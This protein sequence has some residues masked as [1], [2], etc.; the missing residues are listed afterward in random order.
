MGTYE[1]LASFII[2]H[3]GGKENIKS[4]THCLTRLRFDLINN[5]KIEDKT[6]KASKEIVSTQFA[7]GKYQVVIGAHVGDVYEDVQVKLGGVP[8]GEDASGEKMSPLDQFTSVITQ[9]MTPV[10][11]VLG[12]CGLIAAVMAILVALNLVTTTDGAYLILNAMGNACLTFFPVILGYTSAKAFKMNPFSGMILGCALMAPGLAESMSTGD[13]LF[14]VFDSTPLAIPV[15]KTF[16]GIPIMFPSSGYTSTVIPIVFATLVA[17]KIEHFANPRI[18]SVMRMFFTPMV[19]VLGA[20]IITMLVIGPISIMLTNLISWGISALLAVAPVVAYAVY[21]LVYQPLVI[22]GLHWALISVGLIEFATSGSSLL[23]SLIFPASFAH[24]AVCAAVML[25]TKNKILRETSLAAVISACFCIIEPSIYGVTLPVKKRFGICMI[26]GTI[27]GVIN[28]VLGTRMYA[29]TMGI[30]GFAGFI[31]PFTGETQGML[32]CLL[33]VAVTM[34]IGF[35]LTWVTYTPIEDGA[36]K[37]EPLSESKPKLRHE[38]ASVS[39]PVAGVV[40][41]LSE[42]ND[43]AFSGGALGGG[44]CVTLSEGTVVAPFDG[45]LTTLFPTGHALG[46]M[47]DNGVELLVHVGTE[48]VGLPKGTFVKHTVQGKRVHAGD[49]L[50]TFDPAM[51]TAQGCSLETAVVVSNADDYLD[52]LAVGEGAVSVGDELLVAVARELTASANE[53]VAVSAVARV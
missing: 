46:I 29:V 36:P 1:P 4:V 25:R 33:A 39:S 32:A 35:V 2:E 48:T 45:V 17:S 21:A 12:G 6:L 41:S 38:R 10:L 40:K 13:V 44:V 30:T 52:V 15:Y 34:V 37:A 53:P 7:G 19:T 49:T 22:L 31:N 43:P 8:L 24:L 20:G 9:V 42:M 18:P 5:D 47:G 14:T 23:V 3:V 28:G 26:A 50:V 51:V 27:G 16:F 11:G